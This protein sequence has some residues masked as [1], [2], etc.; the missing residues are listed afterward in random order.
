LRYFFKPDWSRIT[1]VTIWV[2]GFVQILYSSGVGFGNLMYFG[3]ERKQEQSIG[4]SSFFL[5]LID[6]ATSILTG[7]TIFLFLGHVST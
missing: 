6:G 2:D 4:K 1:D 5:P 7:I 3:A